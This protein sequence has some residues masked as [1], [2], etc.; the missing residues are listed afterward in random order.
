MKNKTFILMFGCILT[1]AL[2]QSCDDSVTEL[3]KLPPATQ[4]GKNTFGC[5]VEGKAWVTKTS[6]GT[7]G[8]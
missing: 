5:L 2:L 8:Y 4:T 1:L 3:E 7:D 6:T